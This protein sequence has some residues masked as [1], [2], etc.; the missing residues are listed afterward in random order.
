M[1]TVSQLY[2]RKEFTG[3]PVWPESIMSLWVIGIP[4]CDEMRSTQG[5]YSH[6]PAS[7]GLPTYHMAGE[8]HLSQVAELIPDVACIRQLPQ[9]ALT[10]LLQS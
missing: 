9:L 7:P 1:A 10:C 3:T 5:P 2:L 6:R 4:R 8:T